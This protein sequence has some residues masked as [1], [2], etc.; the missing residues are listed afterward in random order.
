MRRGKKGGVKTNLEKSVV[1]STFPDCT[2]ILYP[3]AEEDSLP[4]SPRAIHQPPHRVR[5]LWIKRLRV[6]SLL[7]CA[8]KTR[9]ILN[10]HS[11][12]VCYYEL[13]KTGVVSH[14]VGFRHF[15]F[16]TQGGVFL[17]QRVIDTYMK[18]IALCTL[19]YLFCIN[20]VKITTN[21]NY[22][23]YKCIILL[24]E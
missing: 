19:L 21:L 3:L 18:V 17:D 10:R 24:R 15:T 2:S 16:S 5:P 20:T 4:H 23:G 6:P 12:T 22:S 11:F 13:L 14:N 1:Y 9:N 7:R 8:L